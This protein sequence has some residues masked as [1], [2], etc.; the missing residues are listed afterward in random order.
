MTDTIKIRRLIYLQVILQRPEGKLIQDIYEAM[1][2]DPVQ[3]DWCLQ[4]QEDMADLN[5]NYTDQEI[6]NMDQSMY[7]SIVKEKVRN[8]AFL[9]F[10]EHKSNHEKGHNNNYID[11][12]SSQE[13]LKTNKL[14]NKQTSLLFNLRCSTVRGIRANFS[15]QYH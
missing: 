11:L 3:N 1:K 4:V 12:N 6:R 8:S 2:A 9:R 14:T 15:D 5:I 10:K 7:K 13:Y